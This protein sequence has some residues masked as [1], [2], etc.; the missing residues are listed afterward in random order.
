MVPP[1]L[2]EDLTC[3]ELAVNILIF[4]F[5]CRE[6]DSGKSYA[7]RV[8]AWMGSRTSNMSPALH[9]VHGQG[10]CGDGKVDGNEECDDGNIFQGDGCDPKCNFEKK[11]KCKG[12]PS[13][14]YAHEDDGIC[15]SSEERVNARDCGFYTPP[16]FFDQWAS[17]AEVYNGVRSE[18]CPPESVT[19]PPP[20]D[21]VCGPDLNSSHSWYP[22]D[23]PEA[24]SYSLVVFFE[25]PV[26][27]TAVY[28]Y[29]AS[30]GLVVASPPLISV[31]LISDEMG[32]DG[33]PHFV[34]SRRVSCKAN[35]VEIT[36][37]QDLSKPFRLTKSVRLNLTVPDVSI[38]AVRLRSSESLNPVA[39]S[40]CSSRQLYHPGLQ[41]CVDYSCERPRCQRPLLK[42]ARVVC[43]GLEEGDVCKVYCDEGYSLVG[44]EDGRARLVC[45]DGGWKG[46]TVLCKPVDCRTPLIAHA[47][48][49]CVEGTTFGKTC[50]FKCRPPARFK[51][52]RPLQEAREDW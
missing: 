35:P 15:E 38:A 31:E 6:V 30:D 18:K 10:F 7:Y 36:V 52:P 14:C 23:A 29:L 12:S 17:S 50:S 46:P 28:V 41:K 48:P 2:S 24:S 26:V 42:N 43:Q 19:G 9:Y 49:M 47:D 4:R 44:G 25:K 5:I 37:M 1:S 21:Q 13:L 32:S 34:Q 45:E 3:F 33:V 22:C 51:E 27:A 16:G 39:V 11:F 8:Q 40:R 20:Q